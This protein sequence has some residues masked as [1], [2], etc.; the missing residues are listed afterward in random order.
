MRLMLLRAGDR[1][2]IP[3][4]DIVQNIM[5]ESYSYICICAYIYVFEKTK[6]GGTD[7]HEILMNSHLK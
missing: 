5:K 6:K 1:A 7:K 2:Y 3:L 4:W